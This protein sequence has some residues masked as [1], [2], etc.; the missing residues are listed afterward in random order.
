ML[1]EANLTIKDLADNQ[2]RIVA[3][4]QLSLMANGGIT[5]EGAATL[6][7]LIA[8]LKDLKELSK[9]GWERLNRS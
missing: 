4:I 5:I 3:H 7:D 6:R 1:E 8:G 9:T 2:L